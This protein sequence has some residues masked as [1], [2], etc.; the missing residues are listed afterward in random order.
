[1]GRIKTKIAALFCGI[2]LIV[3]AIVLKAQAA[4]KI[5]IRELDR[6]SLNTIGSVAGPVGLWAN[7]DPVELM[8][9]FDKVSGVNWTP[10]ERD[11]LVHLLLSDTTDTVWPALKSL[12]DTAFLMARMR[13]LFSLGAFHEGSEL[14]QYVPE[15]DRLPEMDTIGFFARFFS[16]QGEA[17]CQAAE[18]QELEYSDQI[19]LI[20]LNAYGDK[21]RAALAYELYRENHANDDPLFTALGDALFQERPFKKPDH[22]MLKPVHLPFI[23]A[24]GQGDLLAFPQPMWVMSFI[25]QSS[26]LPPVI[27]LK[28]MER[29]GG[30]SEAFRTVYEQAET[31]SQEE[32][33]SDRIRAATVLRTASAVSD[34]IKAVSA[35]IASARADGV[36]SQTAPFLAEAIRHIE[37]VPE[38]KALA[39]NA[40]ILFLS[41][42][43]LSAAYLWYQVLQADPIAALKVAPLIQTAGMGLPSLDGLIFLCREDKTSCDELMERLTP[44]FVMP[45]VLSYPEIRPIEKAVYPPVVTAQIRHLKE[46]MKDGEALIKGLI[47][48]NASPTFEGELLWLIQTLLPKGAGAALERERLMSR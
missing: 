44:Y 14:I 19:R 32:G 4:D 12:D 37:P 20:C 26:G 3:T 36:F 11:I 29:M 22:V 24:L 46:G 42:N 16:G 39:Q 9:L 10:A 40:V 35:F 25:K 48:L 27:R 21:A 34:K 17:A 38:N 2:F 1:M 13:T 45:D 33:L 6:L 30:E 41:E 7:S 31:F 43:N 8:R 18:M 47:L 23:E 5:T 28:A 15:K